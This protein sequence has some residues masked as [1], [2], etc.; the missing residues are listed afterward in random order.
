[1][2]SRCPTNRISLW[3]LYRHYTNV[4]STYCNTVRLIIFVHLK[5]TLK[6][7][8]YFYLTGQLVR[9]NESL[10]ALCEKY[11]VVHCKVLRDL[12]D[13]HP[14]SFVPFIRLTIDFV[15]HYLFH[16]ENRV[17]LFDSF[18]VQC[19]NLVKGIVLCAEYKPAKVIE[20]V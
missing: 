10:L 3:N 19:L 6:K 12:L 14:F 5:E 20:G 4:S 13:Q 8:V 9:S 16:I 17:L 1:M 2:D 7:R 11:L 18:V 15:L